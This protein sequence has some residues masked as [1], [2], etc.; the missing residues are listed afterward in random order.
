MNQYIIRR[1]LLIIPTLLGVT[2]LVSLLVELLPGDFV[3]T[4][5]EEYTGQGE[6]VQEF[7]A[8][9]EAQLGLDRPWHESYA[10]WLW[11][12]VR[13]DLGTSLQGSFRTVN[14]ELQAVFQSQWSLAF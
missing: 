9:I 10:D 14:E 6:S 4:L 8:R 11:D 5:L 3:D 7:R 13:G 2:I 12:A 1:I